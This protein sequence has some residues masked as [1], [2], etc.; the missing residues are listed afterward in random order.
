MGINEEV[1]RAFGSH[2]L[3]KTR[4]E[5]AAATGKSEFTPEDVCKDGLC[6][7]GK[8]LNDPAL[9]ADVRASRHYAEVKRLHG[10]FHQA[11]GEAIR[12]AGNGDSAGARRDL[13]HG[14]YAQASQKF[15]DAM[16]RWQRSAA[17]SWSGASPLIKSILIAL[18]GRFSMRLWAAVALPGAAALASLIYIHAHSATL[19]AAGID[20]GWFEGV[21]AAALAGSALLALLL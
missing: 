20:A 1:A 16:F 17:V 6:T 21:L 13:E 18:N 19:Q 11:A 12:K 4:I 3:W 10:D 5:R 8:W 14:G 7:F 2:T 9:S 15:Y